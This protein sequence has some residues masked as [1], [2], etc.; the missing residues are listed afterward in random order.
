M[1]RKTFY[2]RRKV[3]EDDLNTTFDAAEAGDRNLTLGNDLAAR[4]PPSAKSKFGGIVQ[5]FT[6]SNGG[7]PIV[8]LTAGVA[9]D[10]LGRR[11]A[12]SSALDVRINKDGSTPIGA[13]G[14]PAG[15]SIQ[16]SSGKERWVSIYIAWEQLDSDL[17]YDG[18]NEPVYF[19]NTESFYF[20]VAAGAEYIIGAL[21]ADPGS[22]A[23]ARIANKILLWDVHVRNPGT[24]EIYGIHGIGGFGTASQRRSEWFFNY[25][26]TNVILPFKGNIRDTVNDLAD[27]NEDHIA[28]T[29]Y[30]HNANKILHTPTEVWA[31]GGGGAYGLA[32][33]VNTALTGIVDDLNTK[34]AAG[35]VAKS[36]TACVGAQ[37]TTGSALLSTAAA[38]FELPEDTLQAVLIAVKNRLNGLV[39]R[40]GD[41]SIDGN[42][43][44]LTT[45]KDLGKDAQRWDAFIDQLD[46]KTAAVITCAVSIAASI[47]ATALLQINNSNAS[48]KGISITA[49]GATAIGIELT[50]N[51]IT[52]TGLKITTSGADAM[53][54]TIAAASSEAGIDAVNT[55]L[56]A[57][58]SGEGAAGPGVKGISNDAG[59]LGS[60]VVQG[61][62]GSSTN[63][64]GVE[65]LSTNG[66]GLLGASINDDGVQG[67]SDQSA[68]SGLYGTNT[69]ASGGLGIT[70]AYAGTDGSAIQ[71]VATGARTNGVYAQAN[72]LDATGVYAE[73]VDDTAIAVQGSNFEHAE[74]KYAVV[75]VPLG[76]GVSDPTVWAHSGVGWRTLLATGQK[77]RFTFGAHPCYSKLISVAV[78]HNSNSVGMPIDISVEKVTFSQV[79]PLVW[80]AGPTVLSVFSSAQALAAGGSTMWTYLA[81]NQNQ[82]CARSYKSSGGGSAYYSSHINI[83]IDA[84]AIGQYVYGIY[85]AFSFYTVS[86]F[87]ST[88][89]TRVT[90]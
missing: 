83:D 25:H 39:F 46:V 23:P 31:H 40:G 84:S 86:S 57:A 7:Y 47:A 51:G 55:G 43:T 65:G 19:T 56:G 49:N 87:T 41:E 61:V 26:D 12:I 79:D 8:N 2:Y 20:Y 27:I 85:L 54:L 63:G 16:P 6:A 14:E 75:P 66:A 62:F 22:A 68:K 4:T 48:G 5:G 73:A 21:P 71:A 44:P 28:G 77:L 33:E 9:F 89:L 35:S 10:E 74:L 34:L 52:G 81:P 90:P 80:F 76:L 82:Q 13:G 60:G 50:A 17:R 53:P 36:G 70:G 67:T 88:A 59:V 32:T 72:A 64:T 37:A 45:G 11:I 30:K 3:L 42:L 15:V 29:A 18:Y 1:D 78:Q 38:A 58:I 69:A 24:A